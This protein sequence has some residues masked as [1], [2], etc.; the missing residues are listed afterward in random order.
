M[1]NHSRIFFSSLRS[2]SKKSAHVQERL[3]SFPFISGDTF[4]L[5]SNLIIENGASVS[6]NLPE[7]VANNLI[8]F[9]E[10]DSLYDTEHRKKIHHVIDAAADK[11]GQQIKAIVHNGDNEISFIHLEQLLAKGAH[12]FS[13]NQMDN[14]EQ[15]TPIPIGLENAHYRKH[16]VQSDYFEALSQGNNR[17]RRNMFFTSFNPSTNP[18]VRGELLTQLN[19]SKI[20]T[21]NIRLSPAEYR[22]KILN[23]KFVFSPPGNGHDCHR[24]WESIYLGAVPIILKTHLA[25]SLYSELPIWAVDSWEEVIDQDENYL[26]NKFTEISQKSSERAYFP[27]WVK[28]I[29]ED[30]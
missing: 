18:K 24:T 2:K 21:E 29:I 9:I 4:R 30:S 26:N 22:E 7:L 10:V 13:V 6:P 25:E 15:V 23:T 20:C 8:L 3:S 27:H 1:F 12:I 16:G 17:T 5:L 11:Y 14:H 19:K 28:K